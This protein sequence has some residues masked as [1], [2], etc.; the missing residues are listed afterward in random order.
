M[1][2]TP[3]MLQLPRIERLYDFL[4]QDYAEKRVSQEEEK[5]AALGNNNLIASSFLNMEDTLNHPKLPHYLSKPVNYHV[6][7]RF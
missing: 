4:N 7:Q 1:M 5:K 3:R 2:E 6:K